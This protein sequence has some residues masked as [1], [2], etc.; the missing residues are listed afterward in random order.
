MLSVCIQIEIT[1]KFP[2]FQAKIIQHFLLKKIIEVLRIVV[3]Y[4]LEILIK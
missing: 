4:I 2:F 3:R 1:L